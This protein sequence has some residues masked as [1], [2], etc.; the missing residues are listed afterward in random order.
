MAHLLLELGQGLPFG[1]SVYSG[2][3]AES[4]HPISPLTG[5]LNYGPIQPD[6]S[7]SV[8]LVY[9][10]RVVDGANVA[11]ALAFMEEALNG[12]IASELEQLAR[13]QAA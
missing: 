3:G 5:T 9:D 12:E 4:L 11:R 1:V 7:V 6:G 2:L 10:H 8:R 13:G